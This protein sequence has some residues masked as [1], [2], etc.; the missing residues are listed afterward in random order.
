MNCIKWAAA[1]ATALVLSACGGGG[2]SPGTPVGGNGTGN[3]GTGG[4]SVALFSSAPSSLTVK[5]GTSSSFY[6]G[7]GVP[8]YRSSSSNEASLTAS[9]TDNNTL[10]LA[11]LSNGSAEVKVIDSV[12]ASILFNTTVGSLPGPQLFSAVPLSLIVPI[13]TA[14]T[15]VISGGT[16]PYFVSSSNI[17]VTTA[18]L[19]GSGAMTITGSQVGSANVFIFDSSGQSVSSNVTVVN[20]DL[21]TT[22]FITAPSEV[23]MGKGGVES[24]SIG[25]GSPPYAVATD[26]SSLV[27]ASINGTTLTVN[28]LAGGVAKLDITDRIGQRLRFTVTVGSE[29]A[30]FTTAPSVLTVGAG[31]TLPTYLVGGGSSPYIAASA[32][33]AIASASITGSTLTITGVAVGKT[34]I[35][36]VDA[37]GRKIALSV[38]VGVDAPL[39]VTAPDQITVA[40]GA[41]PSYRISGGRAPYSVASDNASVATADGSTGDVLQVNAV[42]TGAANVVVTD[43]TG[44]KKSISVSVSPAATTALR[45]TPTEVTAGVGD[46]LSFNVSGGDPNY[47]VS[48]N[49]LSIAAAT[50]S[51]GITS[52]SNFQ[53]TLLK[54]GSTTVAVTDGLG[55]TVTVA[56]TANNASSSLRLSPDMLVVGE[57]S[58]GAIELAIHGGSSDATYTAYTSDVVLSSVTTLA[59]PNRVRVA[60]GSKGNRCIN[61]T[62]LSTVTADT[63]GNGV[64]TGENEIPNYPVTI[65]VVDNAGNSATSVINIADNGG[66]ACP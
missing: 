26:D 20:S 13:G 59:S 19:S 12:G 64:V 66:A 6:I 57:N 5:A 15:F 56:L 36:V 16:G 33:T 34:L 54:T 3:D 8:P 39:F 62:V 46:V 55:Q 60:L 22:F 21:N 32:N 37:T 24:Y 43:S 23:T 35:D 9:V 40:I 45:V 2:G 17:G 48:V 4:D 61:P 38:S 42:R 29:Y 27:T 44:A 49:N 63:E 58:T 14:P 41:Q 52:G 31:T 30:L 50:P 1:F 65:T 51:S 10:V 11:G 47:T 28:A 53:I 7:G 25:G 18:T